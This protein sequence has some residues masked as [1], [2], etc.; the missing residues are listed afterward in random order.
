MLSWI[1]MCRT[2]HR[3]PLSLHN[4]P[5]HLLLV[6][7]LLMTGLNSGWLHGA[8]DLHCTCLRH[9]LDPEDQSPSGGKPHS[10]NHPRKEHTPQ[11]YNQV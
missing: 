6:L 7:L 2:G 11:Q 8:M 10:G 9:E 3:V 4:D 1:R 5:Q